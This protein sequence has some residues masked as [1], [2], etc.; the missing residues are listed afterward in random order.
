MDRKT[1][2][3]RFTSA[4]VVVATVVIA[5][6][7]ALRAVSPALRHPVVA[8]GATA[9]PSQLTEGHEPGTFAPTLASPSS[10][11]ARPRA[12]ATGDTKSG[13]GKPST[14]RAAVDPAS[15]APPRSSQLST[16]AVSRS[17]AQTPTR[18]DPIGQRESRGGAR[19]ATST[20]PSSAATYRAPRPP[21]IASAAAPGVAVVDS[22]AA[23]YLFNAINQ[24]RAKH[25]LPALGWDPR[26]AKSA[27]AHTIRMARSGIM[28]HQLPAESNLEARE[29]AAAVP[30]K[31]EGECIGWYSDISNG[32]VTAAKWLH[33][34]MMAE[35][36]PARGTANHY[37]TIL[38][39]HASHVGINVVTDPVQKKVWITEDYAAE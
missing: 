9:S 8:A 21:N 10:S 37:S 35:G 33:D 26:L 13:A 5:A 16:P 15:V 14:T 30:G 39:L 23:G 17:V 4:S 32:G 31:V 25:G 12:L 24:A 1:L 2:T 7:L 18:R 34:A 29:A 3:V 38:N 28:S 6:V 11:A 22:A 20:S 36:P 27:G 19:P